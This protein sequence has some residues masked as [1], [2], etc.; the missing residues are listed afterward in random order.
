MIA[1]DTGYSPHNDA[2]EYD[3]NAR[4]IAAGH[5]FAP[6]GYLV[7]G[8]PT[9]IRG[10]AYPYLLGGLYALT[11]DSRTAGR[12]L[13]AVLGALTVLLTFAIAG[14]LW[15]RRVGLVAAFFLAVFHRRC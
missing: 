9:A 13:N 1:A 7:L 11:D 15:G 10:P 8:G 4:S 2:F 6:S 14:R 3:Y 5:G 12:L